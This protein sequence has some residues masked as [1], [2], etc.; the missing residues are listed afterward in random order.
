[1]MLTV[2]AGGRRR[3]VGARR[4]GADEDGWV[5]TVDGVERS[6]RLVQQGG[7]W[8][9]LL[10]S[11]RAGHYD[12]YD[13][14]VEPRGRGHFGVHVGGAVVPVAAGVPAR[15]HGAGAAEAGGNLAIVAPMPGRV[16]KV[17]AQ[18][19]DVVEA[20]QGLVIVEAM[21]MENELR[22]PAAGI[23]REVLVTPG[24]SVDANAVLVIVGPRPA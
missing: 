21:K 22:S 11:S 15:A 4:A 6:V 13:V 16:V 19:G 24:T 20:R 3:I 12:S 18:P 2:E 23:V 9:L 5:V 8:S 14:R 1:M 17:L 10:G 7:S